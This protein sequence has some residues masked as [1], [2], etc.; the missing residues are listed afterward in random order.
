MNMQ[1]FNYARKIVE[2]IRQLKHDLPELD[3]Y[4]SSPGTLKFIKPSI[5]GDR[6]PSLYAEI[7]TDLAVD[8]AKCLKSR[9]ESELA[10]LTSEL[11]AL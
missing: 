10:R 9:W 4:I 6:G 11:E 3:N 7:P 5:H 2:R 1:Q 8:T